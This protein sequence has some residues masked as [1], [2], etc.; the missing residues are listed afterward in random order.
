MPHGVV[1][2]SRKGTILGLSIQEFQPYS[3]ELN[4]HHVTQRIG[5]YARDAQPAILTNLNFHDLFPTE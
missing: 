4:I 5:G 1:P 3:R 2:V